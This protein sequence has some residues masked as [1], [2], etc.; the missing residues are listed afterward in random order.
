MPVKKKAKVKV[1]KQ[2]VNKPKKEKSHKIKSAII[3]QVPDREFLGKEFT[4]TE[5]ELLETQ[6]LERLVSA[7]SIK[8]PAAYK[9]Y[10]SQNTNSQLLQNFTQII[11]QSHDS[12]F[13]NTYLQRQDDRKE[14]QK[15]FVINEI[16][17]IKQLYKALRQNYNKGYKVSRTRYQEIKIEITKCCGLENF[18]YIENLLKREI[19]YEVFNT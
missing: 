12:Q 15:T 9:V 18:L 1:Y 17:R 10:K 16:K 2:I 4:K 6:A 8:S 13:L 11:S 3:W 19:H 5:E 7:A 14:A